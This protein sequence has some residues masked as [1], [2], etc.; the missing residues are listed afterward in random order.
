MLWAESSDF[1]E[2]RRPIRDTF[3]MIVCFNSITSISYVD[4]EKNDR[5]SHAD[6]SD[7]RCESTQ[8]T[9]SNNPAAAD[10]RQTFDVATTKL[11]MT[12]P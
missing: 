4:D 12:M 1:I 6:R 2:R 3:A 10:S 5:H 9:R 7:N 11:F 8:G